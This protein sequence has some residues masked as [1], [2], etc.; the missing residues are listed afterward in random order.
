M[1]YQ[2]TYHSPLLVLYNLQD[3]NAFSLYVLLFLFTKFKET[4]QNPRLYNG[5]AKAL[6]IK[7]ELPP[8][9]HME[10]RTDS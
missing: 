4:N 6:A 2:C 7:T 9:I 3:D 10:D 8:E 5:T 1:H